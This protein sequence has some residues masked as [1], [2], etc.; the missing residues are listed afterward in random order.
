MNTQ[1]LKIQKLQKEISALN[2]KSKRT[3]NEIRKTTKV[4]EKMMATNV[5]LVESSS[6]KKQK[7]LLKNYRNAIAN[8]KQKL[9][10]IKKRMRRFDKV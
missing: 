1:R 2:N 5:K 8:S 6:G 9:S 3:L 4:T 10:K 7:A